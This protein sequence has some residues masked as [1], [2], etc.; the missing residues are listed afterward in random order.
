MIDKIT[1]LAAVEEVL[2][3]LHKNG[4]IGNYAI[5]GAVAAAFYSEPVNTIDL[6]IF[7]MFDPPQTG[8]ILSLAPIYE[9]LNERGYE[10]DHEFIYIAGWP[11]QFIE[12]SHDPLWSDALRNAR[13]MRVNQVEAKVLPPEHLAVMWAEAGRMKDLAKIEEFDKAHAMKR[14]VLLD[15]LEKFGKMEYWKGIQGKLSDEYRF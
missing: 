11:V 1:K 12:S 5:G 10:F 6:D 3:D 8:I 13:T 2:D 4:I 14:S 9:Y 7:F 15:V